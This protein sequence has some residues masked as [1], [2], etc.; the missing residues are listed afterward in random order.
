[1]KLKDKVAVITGG[2]RGIG[3]AISLE[4]AREGANVVINYF[5][6]EKEAYK[7]AEMIRNMG[8]I[9]Y[10]VKA[11]ISRFDEVVRMADEVYSLFNKV[12]ILVN[13]AGILINKSL[14]ETFPEEWMEVLSINLNGVFYT[15]KIFGSRMVLDG[16]GSI[17]NISS[18]AAYTPL[19]NGGAYSASKAGVISLTKQAALEL[20]PKGV[21]VNAV[22]PGPV[23]TDMLLSEYSTEKLEKRGHLMP[24]KTLGYPEDIARLTVFLASDDSR[25]ITGE[26]YGIDG[27]F[28]ISTYSLL[29][30]LL[31]DEDK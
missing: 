29:N 7:V 25:Y 21:R 8:R 3:K 14:L 13:N 6:S 18:V 5:R 31:S 27:G 28:S 23:L 19:V 10:T 17:I 2:A 11:D 12:D 22:C 1:M 9:A 16:G 15:I 30:M 24:L 4:F 20:G 26:A